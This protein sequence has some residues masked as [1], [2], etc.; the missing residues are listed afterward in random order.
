M[1][2]ETD[3]PLPV[4]F[5]RFKHH[6]DY[7]LYRLQGSSCNELID[8]LDPVCNNYIDS[9]TGTMTPKDIG[10]AVVS[11]LKSEQALYLEAFT[12]WVGEKKG[13]RKIKLEDESEWVVR[14]SKDAERY[15]HLHP[16]RTGRFTIRFKGSTLKTVC[17]LKIDPIG[18]G[19]TPSVENVN[20]VRVRA[21]LSP[22]KRLEP[23][24]GILFCWEKLFGHNGI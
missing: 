11:L 13:Y 21:G 5:N 24:K 6:R 2:D 20:R 14:K 10:E 22:V 1:M 17:L 15:I 3:L 9:Y 7:L 4:R 16:A 18:P 8:L 23:G 19:E 12:G